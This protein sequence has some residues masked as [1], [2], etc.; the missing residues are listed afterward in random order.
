MKKIY[1]SHKWKR[2]SQRRSER[3]H[4]R[5]VYRHWLRIY[6]RQENIG[7]S[8]EHYPSSS[9]RHKD[10]DLLVPTIFSVIKNPEET[11]ALFMDFNHAAS[12]RENIHFDMSSV[13]EITP[14]AILYM[15]SRFRYFER[16]GKRLSVSG[17]IPRDPLCATILVTS[18][19]LKHVSYPNKGSIP[20]D[21]N[22]LDVVSGRKVL[23]DIAQKFVSFA[24]DRLPVAKDTSRSIYKTV[25]E[26]MANTRD[27]AYPRPGGDWWLMASYR[28]DTRT[29]HFTFVDNGMTIPAT[30]RKKIAEVVSS[31]ATALV[32]ISSGT[33]ES[34]LINSALLGKY[35]TRTGLS[36]RGKGLP[37]I[38]AQSRN[39]RIKNLTIVSSHGYI[40]VEANIV[41][42][43]QQK[44]QGTLLSWDFV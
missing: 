10:V 24:R 4:K 39:R 25:I 19:F 14:D 40:D 20:K 42:D 28:K 3:E 11:L 32:P 16:S 15:L 30:V 18:G 34:D 22:V 27:H 21:L 1:Q 12:R 37:S 7:Q 29:V 43:L 44:F 26:C 8:H 31:I 9:R 36:Y 2:H 41:K 17:N 38:Y 33:R 35:R 5:D 23:P 6:Y 13:S